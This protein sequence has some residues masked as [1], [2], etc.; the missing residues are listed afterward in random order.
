MVTVSFTTLNTASR[1]LPFK[2]TGL[3]VHLFGTCMFFSFCFV[4][5][6]CLFQLLLTCYQRTW[7]NEVYVIVLGT[8][9]N[10]DCIRHVRVRFRAA[11]VNDLI[12]LRREANQIPLSISDVLLTVALLRF[13]L[14]IYSVTIVRPRAELHG[15]ELSKP[16]QRVKVIDEYRHEHVNT[17]KAATI[18]SITYMSKKIFKLKLILAY[19]PISVELIDVKKCGYEKKI[20]QLR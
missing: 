19:P 6:F 9:P 16:L 1:N 14:N 11:N 10:M 13:H 8:P 4:L 3:F 15:T 18:S 5:L 17:T 7:N 20:L 2:L 12:S